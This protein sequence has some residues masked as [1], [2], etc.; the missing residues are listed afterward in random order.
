MNAVVLPGVD[1]HQHLVTDG[2]QVAISALVIDVTAHHVDPPGRA[3]DQ[4]LRV[5]A[6]PFPG[7]AE[8][9]L[10]G[11]H[12]FLDQLGICAIEGDQL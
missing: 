8:R 5:G 3:H 9:S 6:K 2:H 1:D 4:R 7:V 12:A 10:I 11:P